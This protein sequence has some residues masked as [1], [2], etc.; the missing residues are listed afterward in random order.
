MLLFLFRLSCDED[1][2]VYRANTEEEH[3]N[4]FHVIQPV[5]ITTI[6]VFGDVEISYIGF[7]DESKSTVED[8]TYSGNILYL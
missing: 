6:N 4:F 3:P 8:Q 7:G 1:G 2:W 5:E